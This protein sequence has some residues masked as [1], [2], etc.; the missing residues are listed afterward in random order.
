MKAGP[1]GVMVCPESGLRYREIENEK[2]TCLDLDEG[3][4]LPEFP[5][6]GERSYR[7]IER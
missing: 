1:D 4:E 6:V 3:D 7:E 2:V 5:G